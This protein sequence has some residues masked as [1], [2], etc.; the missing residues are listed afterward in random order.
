MAKTTATTRTQRD[1]ASKNGKM[2]ARMFETRHDMEPQARQEVVALLNRQLAGTFDL[3][4]KTKQAHWNVKGA[5]FYQL[6]ELYDELA[7]GL[8]EHVDTIAERATALG[9]EALGTARIDLGM[10]RD[11]APWQ[12]RVCRDVRR[13]PNAGRRGQE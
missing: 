1:G 11:W 3:F 5:E 13:Q 12:T 9:G 8:L 4:S 7:E 10:N 6:H 2:T